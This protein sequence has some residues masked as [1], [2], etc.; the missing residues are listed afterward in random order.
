[1]NLEKTL[2][3]RKTEVLIVL[4]IFLFAFGI[5]AIPSQTFEGI[6]GFDPFYHG[7]MTKYI[8]QDGHRPENDPISYWPEGTEV[9]DPPLYHYTAAV[10]YELTSLITRG[11]TDFADEPFQRYF[12]FLPVLF[13]AL[14]AVAAYAFGKELRDRKTGLLAGAL[15]S[16]QQTNLFRSMF[17]FAEEDSMGIFFIFLV[18]AAFTWALKTKDWKKGLLAGFSMLGLSLSWSLSIFAA[19]VLAFIFFVHS[20]FLM[21]DKKYKELEKLFKT[22]TAAQLPLFL[23]LLVP[24]ITNWEMGQTISTLMDSVAFTIPVIVFLFGATYYFNYYE[25]KVKDTIPKLNVN[26][27]K[28]FKALGIVL[29]I[30]G[31]GFL[32]FKGGWMIERTEFYLTRAP[33]QT[34]KLGQTIGEEHAKGLS[35]VV[36]ELGWTAPFF[37]FGLLYLP[38]RRLIKY[39]D[40]KCTDLIPFI[41]GI[42]TFFLYMEKAKMGYIFGLGSVTVTAI[43]VMDISK[44]KERFGS[45]TSKLALAIGIFLVFTQAV[46][47]FASVEQHKMSYAPQPGWQKFYD[48]YKTTSKDN[49][50][51]TWWDY[52]HWTSWN[53]MK[54]TLDNTNRNSSKVQ[55]TARIFTDY[56]GNSTQIE[57]RHL[58]QMK[59][60]EVTHVAVD[61]ILLHQKWGALTFLGDNQCIPT[62]DLQDMDRSFPKELSQACGHGMTYSGQMGISQCQ[63][64]QVT[65][66]SGG[67][68][69]FV[70]C[71]LF[72][73]NPLR[74]TP[75]EW[76]TIK[77]AKWPGYDLAIP[78]GDGKM[79]MKVYGQPDY[80]LMY[81]KMGNQ[82]IP[83]AP[84]N[85]MLGPRLFFKD[86][87]LEHF[88]LIE[89]E[90]VPNREV[91]A[92]K[93]NYSEE[94]LEST[95]GEQPEPSGETSEPIDLGD[96][97]LQ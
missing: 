6:Y 7:R 55:A 40:H 93:V 81:F 12:S 34:G 63:P 37:L 94:A 36:N 2:K 21:V 80:K 83:D 38:A 11:T 72:Q 43:V 47:A 97:T 51:M 77:N 26:S 29:L 8:L 53:G 91:V 75:E 3:D 14:A 18:F 61:R 71:R 60:W 39:K 9:N 87:N 66:E 59:D 45:W 62:E 27:K 42:V 78:S 65:S 5:R 4:G 64:K 46:P 1:M 73:G 35:G 88:E 69:K 92:Y 19:P 32:A 89:N 67:T 33:H 13:G 17:G 31:L 76:N 95:D 44:L 58:K 15:M 28:A 24:F 23:M 84:M 70:E 41:L 16:L 30:L 50:L 68:Q 96:T 57:K 82:I 20:I 86:P 49:V 10:G 79:E 74:F 22:Y 54:T 90:A 52:G 25:K 48:W 56:Y 85:Y